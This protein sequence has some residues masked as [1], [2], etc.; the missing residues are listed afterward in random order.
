MK[1]DFEYYW[2]II[3][4]PSWLQVGIWTIRNSS[5]QIVSTSPV[6]KWTDQED[7]IT[8]T[9]EALSD[10]VKD[11]PEDAPEPEKTVFGLPPAWV[12]EGQVKKEYLEYIRQLCTNLSLKPTGFVVLP[13]AIAHTIKVDDGAPLTGIIVGVHKSEI[14]VTMFKLGNLVGTVQVG[15]SVSIIDDIVEG[16][17]RFHATEGLPSKFI[18]YDGKEDELEDI[19]QELIQADWNSVAGEHVKI[20]HTP[21]VEIINGKKKVQAVSLAGASELEDISSIIS[22]EEEESTK[23]EDLGF[24]LGKDVA[25]TAVPHKEERTQS[26][27]TQHDEVDNLQEPQ[28]LDGVTHHSSASKLPKLPVALPD[29]GSIFSKVKAPKPTLKAKPISSLGGGGKKWIKFVIPAV[30]ILAV[31]VGV[32]WTVPRAE[33]TVYV[34]PQILEETTEVSFEVGRDSADLGNRILPATTA[35][36]TVDGEKTGSVTGSKTVGERATGTVTIQNGTSSEI[37]LSASTVLVGPND[38]KFSIN[39]AVDIPEAV[40]TR[41]PGTVT[42]GIT[43]ADIGS[44]Y[45][46]AADEV[47]TVGNFPRSEVDAIVTEALTGGSS[48]EIT[49]VAE[50]DIDKLEEELLVELK[51]K[52]IEQL[53]SQ[54]GENEH[55]IADAVQVAVVDTEASNKVGDEASSVKL[56]LSAEVEGV[57]VSQDALN[58]LL[59][60]LLNEKVP[61]GYILKQDQVK[62]ELTDVEENEDLW[63]ANMRVKANLIPIVEPD[64]VTKKI[65]GK[66]PNAAREILN[67][68][69]GHSR[70]EVKIS[71]KF[72]SVMG[73][74]P[75]NEEHISVEVV[76]ER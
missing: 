33:V 71:P 50:S 15:R 59:G 9:D 44:E 64:E 25:E 10:A 29:F 28:P 47:F 31:L 24:V 48:R 66:T 19:S 72:P 3:I 23:P 53:N 43:A 62:I 11:F 14:D 55:F 46:L 45:N 61:A 18:L 74:I 58:G 26:L 2:S 34:A 1:E 65:R 32:W 5:V 35:T 39:E 4:E 20:L 73:I 52:G 41:E 63:T 12:S 27:P 60:V 36:T 56:S 8:V 42:V 67:A 7:L 69:P 37:S 70:V 49:A 17:A 54:A 30:V 16:L 38:L 57:M 75:Y 22:D 40:S 51:E 6:R 21:Q 13:E 68:I 76:A